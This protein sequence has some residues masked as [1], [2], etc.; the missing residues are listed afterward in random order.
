M[1][2]DDHLRDMA[3]R[4]DERQQVITAE[5]IIQRASNQRTRS[6]TT[7]S[8]FN[9][10]RHERNHVPNPG[11][12]E[13]AIVVE[14]RTPSPTDQQCERTKRVVVAALLA[15]AAV[16]AIMLVASRKDERV[17]PADQ[18]SPTTTV[19]ARAFPDEGEPIEPGTYFIDDVFPDVST[20]RI[21][22]IL[23][24]LGHGWRGVANR[25]GKEGT[26]SMNLSHPNH[27]FVDSCHTENGFQPGPL[28]TLDGMVT[29]LHQQGGGWLDVTTPS[30]ASVDGYAGKTF[31]RT[32][33]PEFRISPDRALPDSSCTRGPL[34]SWTCACTTDPTP[35]PMFRY[36]GDEI[37]I[38]RILDLNGTIIVVSATYVPNDEEPGGPAELAAVLDSIRIEPATAPGP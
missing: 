18:P 1:T 2:I 29:A 5:A 20:P 14:L 15:A 6:L 24:T 3:R 17:R 9:D 22:R 31:Q 37:E 21:P 28:T 26:G 10:R 30:D 11:S 32:A 33:P 34:G 25:F 12:E 19:P 38:L 4:A 16:I 8:R 35:V 7:R 23:V 13:N 27:V 36:S